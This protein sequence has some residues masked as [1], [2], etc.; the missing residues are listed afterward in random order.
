MIF[1]PFL[2]IFTIVLTKFF[3]DLGYVKMGIGY[4]L[5]ILFNPIETYILFSYLQDWADILKVLSIQALPIHYV[6]GVTLIL[7]FIAILFMSLINVLTKI[8]QYEINSNFFRARLY[9]HISSDV[10]WFLDSLK[11]T[12]FRHVV[13]LFGNKNK[14]LLKL[15]YSLLIAV[16]LLILELIFTFVALC[17]FL[18]ILIF[19]VVGFFFNQIIK[20]F[21]HPMY[22]SIHSG[23]LYR[24]IPIIEIKTKGDIIYKGEL[25]NF[26]P[27]NA[28]E[29]ESFTL[30]HVIQ[31]TL[32]PSSKVFLPQNRETYVFRNIG[33]KFTIPYSEID[34]YNIWPLANYNPLRIGELSKDLETLDTKIWYL[35]L[36]LKYQKH[37][38]PPNF[39]IIYKNSSR[40]DKDKRKMC[41]DLAKLFK[42]IERNLNP[43]VLSRIMYYSTRKK[44][45]LYL[46]R[47]VVILDYPKMQQLIKGRIRER[48]KISIGDFLF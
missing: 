35:G 10:R 2:S 26:E 29:I 45:I 33:S 7:M 9:G 43:N 3:L 5:S 42:H 17:I 15:L 19:Y 28:N 27:K 44:W 23:N 8:F 41:S 31:Y 39:R 21:N 37:L 1:V 24:K 40:N 16:F 14:I 36:I 18:A 47:N 48:S 4:L 25:K 6:F 46:Y 12:L 22:E 38:D 11:R 13:S 20:F 34:N 30:E 32:K